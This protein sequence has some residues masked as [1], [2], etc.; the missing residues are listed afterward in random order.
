[1]QMKSFAFLTV[2]LKSISWEIK[3]SYFVFTPGI[4]FKYTSGDK[5]TLSAA[6]RETIKT[7]RGTRKAKCINIP[8]D[9]GTPLGLVIT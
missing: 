6:G 8:K 5:F 1:M 4:N 2:K 3:V 7:R 9:F